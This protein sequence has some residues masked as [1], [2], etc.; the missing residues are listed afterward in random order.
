M[1]EVVRG[2]QPL[3]RSRAFHKAPSGRATRGRLLRTVPPRLVRGARSPRPQAAP[4]PTAAPPL[5]YTDT[6]LLNPSTT[7]QTLSLYQT[8]IVRA[9]KRRAVISLTA[10]DPWSLADAFKVAEPTGAA[11]QQFYGTMRGSGLIAH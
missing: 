9:A 1:R 2:R 3:S 11:W 7:H 8:V 4:L 10:H 5:P 6:S